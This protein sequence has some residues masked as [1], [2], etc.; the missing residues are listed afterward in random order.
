MYLFHS[1]F[2][3]QSNVLMELRKWKLAFVEQHKLEMK[4]E[5]ERHA[6]QTAGLKAEL[7]SLKQLLHTY[8]TSNQRKDEVC[9]CLLISSNKL[10]PS[11]ALSCAFY[12]V[13][14]SLCDVCC[15]SFFPSGDCELEPGVGQTKREGREDEGPHPVETST[16]RGQRGGIQTGKEMRVI[17]C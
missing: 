5:R 17:G 11:L 8:E 14:S 16:C 1:L 4:K 12:R 13:M 6:A 7:D 9:T 15:L 3:N 10:H 2:C